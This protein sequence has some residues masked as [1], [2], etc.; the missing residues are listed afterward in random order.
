MIQSSYPISRGSGSSTSG[1]AHSS[2]PIGYQPAMSDASYSSHPSYTSL[3]SCV[4][5]AIWRCRYFFRSYRGSLYSFFFGIFLFAWS[6]F[7]IYMTLFAPNAPEDVLADIAKLKELTQAGEAQNAAEIAAMKARISHAIDE[8][9]SANE[10]E[11][12]F[13]QELKRDPGMLAQLWYAD[14]ARN[15]KLE[16]FGG[17]VDPAMLQRAVY[18]PKHDHLH[19]DA[20][21]PNDNSNK[22]P[23]KHTSSDGHNHK[24]TNEHI[25][26]KGGN[27]G[28]GRW[29]SQL[30]KS[31]TRM[32]PSK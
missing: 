13:V 27:V 17:K 16:T 18:D 26:A 8:M 24:F 5:L 30:L 7:L 9:V 14:Q 28:F 15:N 19:F 25:L 1:A 29:F 23:A 12:A 10:R 6:F 2:I 21:H 11:S 3:K 32:N 31:S 20:S 4:A 22:Q